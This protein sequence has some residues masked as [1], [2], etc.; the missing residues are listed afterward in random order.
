MVIVHFNDKVDKCELESI[1]I[2]LCVEVIECILFIAID[3]E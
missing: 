2:W 3:I 1:D